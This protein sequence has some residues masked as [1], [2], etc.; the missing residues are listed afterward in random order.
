MNFIKQIAI[1]LLAGL[2]V[3]CEGSDSQQTISFKIK[4]QVFNLPESLQQITEDTSARNS[5]TGII[6]SLTQ[7]VDGVPA[8]HEVNIVLD[9]DFDPARDTRAEGDE[10]KPGWKLPNMV[11]INNV[12]VE[13]SNLKLTGGSSI[14]VV[15]CF[16]ADQAVTDTTTLAICGDKLAMLQVN[17]TVGEP[18]GV[19]VVE[20]DEDGDEIQNHLEVAG[21]SNPYLASPVAPAETGVSIVQDV[22]VKEVKVTWAAPTSAPTIVGYQVTLFDSAG[23]ALKDPVTVNASDSTEA[24]FVVDS[25]SN[26]DEVTAVI[27]SF[28]TIDGSQSVSLPAEGTLVISGLQET[29]S[30][31]D[32]TAPLC[33]AASFSLVSNV[34]ET[35][36]TDNTNINSGDVVFGRSVE[37]NIENANGCLNNLDNNEEYRLVLEAVAPNDNNIPMMQY[38]PIPDATAFQSGSFNTETTKL[39]F[40]ISDFSAPADM[41]A[42]FGLEVF[43]GN[44]VLVEGMP[45]FI[46][47]LP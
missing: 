22:G 33:P 27:R 4:D 40:S 1:P 23:M 13:A 14:E 18:V 12:D 38:N 21:G 45:K 20:P 29:G 7:S 10:G 16:D 6:V 31:A 46:K 11:S 17:Y 35:E 30:Q 39:Q 26:N 32:S 34:T 41:D 9:T 2:L 44:I 5:L 19:I 24:V 3:G 37:F 47:I 43:F 28:A 15:W 42:E 8:P 36:V 25:L